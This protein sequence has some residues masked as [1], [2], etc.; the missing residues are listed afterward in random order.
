M[1]WKTWKISEIAVRDRD[2]RRACGVAGV[3]R[4]FILVRINAE[5]LVV[6][7]PRDKELLEVWDTVQLAVVQS[8]GVH[9]VRTH[10]VVTIISCNCT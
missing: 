9:P 10:Y 8:E 5:A 7:S 2:R 4:P 3:R 1:R 6:V